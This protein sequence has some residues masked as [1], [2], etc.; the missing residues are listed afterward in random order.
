MSEELREAIET[1]QYEEED[2][3]IVDW[4]EYRDSYHD[5]ISSYIY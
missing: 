2:Y 5:Y 3:E 1:D 4:D